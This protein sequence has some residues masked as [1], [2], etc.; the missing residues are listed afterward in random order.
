[1]RYSIVRKLDNSESSLVQQI[2]DRIKKIT[3]AVQ[4]EYVESH[5]VS[6]LIIAVGGDGTVLYGMGQ[7]ALYDIPVF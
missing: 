3:A 4:W 7:S 2:V 5:A 6:E 1:M